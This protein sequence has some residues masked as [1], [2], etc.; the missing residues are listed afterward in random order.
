M[1]RL[2]LAGVAA[3]VALTTAAVAELARPIDK[4]DHSYAGPNVPFDVESA[5]CA[6]QATTLD[7]NTMTCVPSAA[8]P[9]PAPSAVDLSA[10]D[11]YWGLT[12][13]E[14]SCL[15]VAAGNDHKADFQRRT[16]PAATAP[17]IPDPIDS[18]N[19]PVDR[20]PK[21]MDLLS[22]GTSRTATPPPGS[23]RTATPSQRSRTTSGFAAMAASP[24]STADQRDA[25]Y[26]HA[27]RQGHD[28]T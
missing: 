1:T 7:R 19:I 5:H 10:L 18:C 21:A 4:D 20:V 27:G 15:F 2:L 28:H 23:R 13:N 9:A 3:L 16:L 24:A 12:A 14:K 17:L 8:A 6:D 26:D 25:R 22:N 11:P